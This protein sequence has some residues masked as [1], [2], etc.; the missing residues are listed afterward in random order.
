MNFKTQKELFDYIWDNRPHYSQLTGKPLIP[1]GG[2]LW[3]NQFLHIL[4]K[5]TYKRYKFNPDNI[6]LAR[7]EE[8]DVQE[9]FPLFLELRQKLTLEYHNKYK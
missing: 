3:H 9:R 4:P 1:K 6:L 7:P 8:H 5:G 2:F